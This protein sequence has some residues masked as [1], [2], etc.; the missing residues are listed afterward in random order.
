MH[1]PVIAAPQPPL[2]SRSLVEA[3]GANTVFLLTAVFPLIVSASALLIDEPRVGQQ[4]ATQ[5]QQQQPQL[6]A[7]AL[8]QAAGAAPVSAQ[9]EQQQ[10]QVGLVVAASTSEHSSGSGNDSSSGSWGGALAQQL[11][12]Q[13]GALWGAVR[14]KD[15]LL[16]ATFVFLWQVGM[17]ARGFVQCGRRHTRAC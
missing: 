5:Q 1:L 8:P 10:Q 3:Y 9:H 2:P 7:A 4:P 14:Q 15:I 11:A 13:T 6:P 16:P 12:A 17:A